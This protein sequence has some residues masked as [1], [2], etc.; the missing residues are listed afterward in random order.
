MMGN[1]A[2]KY[3]KNIIKLILLSPVGMRET[4]AAISKPGSEESVAMSVDFS[5]KECAGFS[6]FPK[7]V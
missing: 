5:E 7:H 2:L 3:P 4:D 1:Y 6:D